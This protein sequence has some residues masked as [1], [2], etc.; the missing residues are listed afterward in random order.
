M[1]IDIKKLKNC[2]LED[3]VEIVLKNYQVERNSV[4]FLPPG[5]NFKH[6][7]RPRLKKLIAEETGAVARANGKIIGFITGY[8][9][10]EFWGDCRGIYCPDYGHGVMG[11]N[12]K[13]VYQKLYKYSANEWV[14]GG[15]TH[16]ALTVYAHDKETI[17]TFSWLGF[18][19]RCVDAM[20]ENAAIE[21]NNTEVSIKKVGKEG[22][23]K[24]VNLQN[25]LRNY[26]TKS[27]VFIPVEK[28]APEKYLDNWLTNNNRHLWVADK[29]KEAVGFM[30]IEPEG[31]RFITELE[32]VMNITGAYVKEEYRQSRIGASLLG[33]IQ[34][35]LLDND[36]NLCGV[37]YESFNLSGSNF[38]DNFFTP[39][40]YSLVRRID[41]RVLM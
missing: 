12:R 4:S 20:R 24:I 36:Y 19:L 18:G 26:L 22:I 7:I 10:N 11:D 3:V 33:D 28:E 13:K 39:Y 8:K 35:W 29:D 5:N 2:H 23:S 34:K 1:N 27:P 15:F 14:E 31:E 37:D 40:T 6:L 9:I 30:K 16:H 41:E 17:D 32:E 25:K 21:K 38:W